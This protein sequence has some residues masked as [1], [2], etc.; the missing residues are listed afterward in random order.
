[1]SIEPPAGRYVLRVIGNHGVIE[2]R[3][4]LQAL[5]TATSGARRAASP[6]T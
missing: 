5:E 2:E 4:I 3:E 6:P 1:M